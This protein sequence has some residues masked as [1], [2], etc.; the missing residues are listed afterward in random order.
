MKSLT[1]QFLDRELS[2]RDFALGIAALGFSGAAADSVA[3]AVDTPSGADLKQGM[4]FNGNGG[5]ALAECLK[6]AQAEY[7][8]D[9]NSTGQTSF[10]DALITRPELKMIVAL[11]EGQ[12]V[13]MAHGY[14]L[15]SGKPGFLMLPSIG[16]PNAMSNLYNAWKDRSAL[17]VFSDGSDTAIAGR[18][19]FQQIDG[20]QA[21][22]APFTKWQW[23]VNHPDRIP[24]MVRRGIKLATTPTGGPVYV[25]MP[26]NILSAAEIDATLFVHATTGMT[27]ASDEHTL[28][29]VGCHRAVMPHLP[30]GTVLSLLP[31]EHRLVGPR[32]LLMHALVHR[33]HGASH[34]VIDQARW[35]DEK[36]RHAIDELTARHAD[37]LG[38]EFVS[39]VPGA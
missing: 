8:F 25:R 17:V 31:L 14:E 6:A 29:K 34:V 10:Y 35:T 20:L 36:D 2:R 18:D 33:N 23:S 9:T 39:V 1:K 4:P 11:Q 19:G 27:V 37:E 3:A 21:M 30:H 12:A 38:V 28:T 22:T 24:E 26:K 7:V 5:E 15:A 32:E 16:M 13:S